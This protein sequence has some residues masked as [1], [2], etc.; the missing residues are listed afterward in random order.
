MTAPFGRGQVVTVFRSTLRDEPHPTY[1][2]LDAT[3]RER[4]AEL[5]GLVD[6]KS[7]VAD[8]GERVTIVTFADQESHHR[9]A[10]DP[11]HREAQALGR[12]SVYET[13][14][15]QVCDCRRASSFAEGSRFSE[16]P[17]AT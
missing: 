5:G 2:S 13:Y 15:I 11:L 9:W 3:L 8:D 10:T 16:E 17:S 12:S 7:F 1:L 6:I 14:S 4:A